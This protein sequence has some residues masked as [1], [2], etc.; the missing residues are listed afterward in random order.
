MYVKISFI[1]AVDA[2]YVKNR[3]Y[4]LQSWT[5]NKC[6]FS[7]L[8]FFGQ[9]I[10]ET[11]LVNS[12]MLNDD[13]NHIDVHLTTLQNNAKHIK[14][15]HIN[16]QSTVSIFDH[17]CLLIELYSI[18]VITMSKTWLEENNL[19]IQYVTIP[20]YTHAFNN[21]DKIRGGGGVVYIKESMKFKRREDL[22]KHYP[23]MEYLWIEIPGRNRHSK[24]LL[25]AIY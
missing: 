1:L 15:M 7:K 11:T 17:L 22:E 16:T 10:V 4:H 2:T 13:D 21:R 8:P 25:G 6:L 18:D 24:L 20:G 9:D 12:S 23:T 19:L 3:S 5:C 14:I